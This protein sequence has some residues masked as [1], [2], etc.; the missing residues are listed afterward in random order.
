MQSSKQVRNP[1]GKGGFKDNPQNRSNGRWSKETSISYQVNKLI[2]MSQDEFKDFPSKE[3]TM[4][5]IIAWERVNNAKD[6]LNEAAFVTDR[7]E[8]RAKETVEIETR[9]EQRVPTLAER[10]ASKVYL[11]ELEKYGY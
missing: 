7:T 1:K 9:D 6:K 2:R 4:A 10:E 11:K 8:G 5:E 3:R